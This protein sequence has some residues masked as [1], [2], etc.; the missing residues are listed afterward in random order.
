MTDQ[1]PII[2]D[3]DLGILVRATT[4]LSDGTVLTHDWYAG[5]VTVDDSELELMLEG[6]TADEARS[7]IPRV[8]ETI[9]ALGGL[10]RLASDAVVT[11]FSQGTPE[12]TE[13][14]TAASDLALETIE[15]SA[16]GTIVL[17][18][19]DTCGEH[20][21]EGYWPA[22]HLGAEGQIAQVTVES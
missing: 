19:I 4:E 2:D 13:L 3:P 18:L 17:H 10:R 16:D 15:A 22:V 21:P 7:L 12:P 6:T 11:A 20:F 1:H 9:A 14:D 5:T 8:R